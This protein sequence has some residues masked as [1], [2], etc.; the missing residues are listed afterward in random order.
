MGWLDGRLSA[1]DR[2]RRIASSRSV[3]RYD[4]VPPSTRSS[5]HAPERPASSWTELSTPSTS[6]SARSPLRRPAIALARSGRTGTGRPLPL[7]R[8]DLPASPSLAERQP[9]LPPE[10]HRPAGAAD[11]DRRDHSRRRSGRGRRPPAVRVQVR[12]PRRI[13]PRSRPRRRSRRTTFAHARTIFP[14]LHDEEIL[15]VEVQRARITEPVHLLGG[16]S[17]VPDMFPVSGLALAST[18]HVYPE[19]VNGQAVIRRCRACRPGHPRA[20]A[21]RAPGG[22]GMTASRNR[23]E[24]EH[25]VKKVGV[26]GAAGSSARTSVNG[27]CGRDTRWWAS[28]TSRTGRMANLARVSRS[29][30]FPVR[31]ARLRATTEASRCIRR[32]R[33]DRAPGREEDP[34]L[35]RA[36][37]TLEVN[38][39]GVHA[40][41]ARR[42]LARRRP[43]IV[44]STSDVYG[45]AT[46]PFAEDGSLMLGP[47]DDPA[48]GVRRLEALRRAPRARAGRG[49]R[50]Q[51]RRSCVSSM[52]MGRNHPSWWGGPVAA[53][54]EAL[55]DG[56]PDGDPR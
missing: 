11:D 16:A 6:S 14:A 50:S 9:V 47:S 55:L 52:S 17:D 37:L 34:A 42:A 28:T 49:A 38:V 15:A 7:S 23:E 31:G 40:A 27:S 32:V 8:R 53:F 25:I 12:R 54:T 39:A 20:H 48:L 24:R 4:R 22:G 2:A 18:A 10:H 13:R 26:T 43:R 19:M 36:L 51:R 29:S 30:R 44:T 33:R 45:N 3:V 35:R 5:A 41:C 1:L 46:P 21:R 56:E